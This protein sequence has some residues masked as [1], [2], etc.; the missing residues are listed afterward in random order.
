MLRVDVYV[1]LGTDKDTCIGDRR[2]IHM[3][4]VD[5]GWPDS[6]PD[7]VSDPQP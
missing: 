3:S 4:G 7:A 5:I 2:Q 1:G 6:D